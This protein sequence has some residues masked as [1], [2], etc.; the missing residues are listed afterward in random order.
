M[1]HFGIPHDEHHRFLEWGPID[2]IFDSWCSDFDEKGIQYEIGGAGEN[3]TIYIHQTRV[4]VDC[5]GCTLCCP[6]AEEL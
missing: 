6:I 2:E 5:P 4:R 1:T 3:W